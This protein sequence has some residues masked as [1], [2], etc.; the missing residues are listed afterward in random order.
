MTSAFYSSLKVVSAGPVNSNESYL[1]KSSIETRDS[2]RTD[3]I[4]K[5]LMSAS[6][7]EGDQRR[8]LKEYSGR[9]PKHVIDALATVMSFKY[10][11]F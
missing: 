2:A 3:L 11:F 9:L 7:G 8:R 1:G 10:C 4:F 5:G 6:I